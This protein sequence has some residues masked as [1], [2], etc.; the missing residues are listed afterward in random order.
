MNNIHPGPLS[1]SRVRLM[2]DG[3]C[4]CAVNARVCSSDGVC[5]QAGCSQP[6]KG[7]EPIGEVTSEVYP[8]YSN[9]KGIQPQW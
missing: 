9:W 6:V 1:R 2:Q 5:K 7:R 4:E 8:S 3:V